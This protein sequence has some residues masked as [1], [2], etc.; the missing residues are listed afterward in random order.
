MALHGSNPTGIDTLGPLLASEG[1]TLTYAT[2]HKN[3]VLR[4]LVMLAKVSFVSNIDYVLIDTYS[5]TNFWYAFWVSRICTWRK[6]K[7]LPILHGGNLPHRWVTHPYYCRLLFHQAYR[8]VC[9]SNYMMEAFQKMDCPNLVVIPNAIASNQYVFKE[10][11]TPRPKLLWVRAFATIYNP[12]MALDV[13]TSLLKTYPEAELC[14][15]G[16]DKDGNSQIIKDKAVTLGLPVTFI[17]KMPKKD[18]IAL[19]ENFDFFINTSHFDNTPVSVVEAM[20]LGLGVVSTNVGG[21]PFLIDHQQTGWLVESGDSEAMNAAIAYLLEHPSQYHQMGAKAKEKASTFDWE[22]VRT[23]W[24][25]IL[26]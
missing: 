8:N 1:Y 15:V 3:K 23:Y 2:S 9:P 5:T 17:G 21:M 12:T 4:L 25:R 19:S 11:T 24:H 20:H 7:Y 6:L 10:R 18:W 13:L 14:M 16:P 26:K 22:M